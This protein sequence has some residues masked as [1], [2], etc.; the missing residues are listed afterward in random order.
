MQD[1]TLKTVNI[2]GIEIAMAKMQEVIELACE[3]ISIRKMLLIGVVNCAKIVNM[4]K[5]AALRRSIEEAD[6]VLADGLPVVWLS[7][8]VGTPLPERI[9]GIDLMMELLKRADREHYNVYFLGAREDVLKK[10][11]EVVKKSYP[12]VRVAGYRNG[13]FNESQD[14]DV[15]TDI[16]DSKADILF[17]G[18]SPPK[19]EI[20]LSKWHTYMNVP[21]CHGVGGS[22]DVLAGVTKRAPVWM[23]KLGLEW[24]YRVI[25]EPRRMWKRYFKTNAVFMAIAIKAILISYTSRL[26]SKPSYQR[27][28]EQR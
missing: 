14:Q 17:V 6:I 12:C 16:R 26:V 19:K 27:D 25:Q 13:Y 8:M 1:K 24:L 2:L 5:D 18:I 20:F 11:I 7:K 22:F 10:V 21:V 15:A 28:T 23:Q 9:A 3:H 4:R